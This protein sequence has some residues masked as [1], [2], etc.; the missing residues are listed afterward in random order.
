MKYPKKIHISISFAVILIA[1]SLFLR[2]SRTSK[3]LLLLSIYNLLNKMSEGSRRS[4]VL[5]YQ[6]EN[7]VKQFLEVNNVVLEQK[8]L[9]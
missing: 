7:T 2:I 1:T 3:H 6:M 8:E 4:G 5:W 9:F